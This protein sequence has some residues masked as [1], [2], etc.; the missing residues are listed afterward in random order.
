MAFARRFEG[1]VGITVA[2]RLM[3][4][5]GLRAGGL[6]CGD[7]WQDTRIELP[8]VKDGTALRDVVSG[9]EHVVERGGLDVSRLLAAFPA[10]VLVL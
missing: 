10:A 4:S 3:A 1:E 9:T 7:V 8:F 5:L 6:P 2:P